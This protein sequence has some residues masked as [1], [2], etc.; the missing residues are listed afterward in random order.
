MVYP[1]HRVDYKLKT[2]DTDKIRWSE[3]HPVNLEPRVQYFI[4]MYK[5]GQTI[6]PILVHK[7]PNGKYEV[8]D[9]HARLEA[10]KRLGV[11]K[12]PAVE[13]LI[14][15]ILGKIGA[16][17]RGGI[18]KAKETYQ[19]EREKQK[20]KQEEEIEELKKKARKGNR[21]VQRYLKKKGISWVG[22]EAAEEE[23]D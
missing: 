4:D 1:A 8:L 22:K 6:P 23:A 2:L 11:K 16:S 14:G 13:N 15:E 17:F 12:I 10:F 9:G 18:T 7:L 3:K 19:M 5:R 20:A 21:A